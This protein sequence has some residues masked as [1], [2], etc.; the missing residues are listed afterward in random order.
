M[1]PVQIALYVVL[2]VALAISVVTDV[3]SRLI[4]NVV[5]FPTM[6]LAL[7]LRLALVGVRGETFAEAQLGLL[8]GVI[9]LA[10]GWFAF[11]LM[12]LLGGMGGGDVKLM[13]AVGA[14]LGFP[15]ILYALMFTALVGG[16]QAI[17]VL[18]WDGSLA[19]TMV[20]AGRRVAHALHLR[21]IE[22]GGEPERKYVP[23][24]VAIALGTV[25]AVWWDLTHPIAISQ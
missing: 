10:V 4:Y 12:Y 23:Y 20:N 1:P 19:K 21:R 25:W 9:G 8:P 24:G 22:E 5:T 14:A 11:Y 15:V 7:L 16:L 2:G 3:R 6:G 18:L 17:L 13:G